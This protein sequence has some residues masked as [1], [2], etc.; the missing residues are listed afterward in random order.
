VMWTRQFSS[1]VDATD[2]A[3]LEQSLAILG[4]KRMI[5][6]HTVQSTITAYCEGKVWA[7]DVGMSRYYGGPIEVLEIVGDEVLTVLRL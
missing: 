7:V 1:A 3:V 6:A 2:C 5:V 4:A